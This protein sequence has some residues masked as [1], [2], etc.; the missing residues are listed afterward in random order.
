VVVSNRVADLN[1]S[2]QSGGLAVGLADA[3]NAQGGLWFGWDGQRDGT[4]GG[5]LKVSQHGNV[6]SVGIPISPDDFAD[7]YLGF[8]NGVL[9]PLFHYR[10]DLVN[11]AAKAFEG[12]MR[13]NEE[14]ARQLMPVLKPDDVI[15]IHDYHLIPLASLLRRMGCRQKIGHFLHTPFPPPE[16]LSAMPHHGALVEAMLDY[17]L[18]GFQTHTDVGNLKSYLTAHAPEVTVDEDQLLT[19]ERVTRVGRFPIGIDVADFA[20]LSTRSIP[21]ASLADSPA[22]QPRRKRII[23]VDRLDYSKGLPERFRAFD[24]LLLRHPEHTR[25]VGFIQIAPLTREEMEAYENIRVELEQLAG[26]V[27]GR[28]ADLDW[29]PVQYLCRPLPRDVLA[30][31][32]R[33]SDVGFVTPLRDGM[34]LVA[35]EFVAAQDPDDPGVLILSQF[36]GAAEE[37]QE[38]L[39]VNPY[40]IEDMALQL[41][42]ALTMPI[43]ERRERHAALWRHI[44]TFDATAWAES[45]LSAL[46]EDVDT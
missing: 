42:L 7:Y 40:D 35:K 30:P 11:I 43:E 28:F 23:G 41:H 17:D 27:N 24:E 4:T 5:P 15:W 46:S 6:T 45:F 9:W 34:N 31:L 3:I 39:I 25:Q 16:L 22:G 44:T 2:V 1:S 8:A 26:S 20:T 13:V 14:F 21:D 29:T 32:M 12:Y 33:Q 18:L 38:A 19:G 37:M 10:L 36:A